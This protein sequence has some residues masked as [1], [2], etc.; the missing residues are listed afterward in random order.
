MLRPSMGQTV[1]DDDLLASI[2]TTAGLTGDAYTTFKT[3]FRAGAT[4]EFVVRTAVAGQ[5]GVSAVPA[6]RA[7]GKIIESTTVTV[8]TLPVLL[9]AALK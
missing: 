2:A 7:N 4:Q 3:C 6:L 1:S 8:K 9:A 5:V